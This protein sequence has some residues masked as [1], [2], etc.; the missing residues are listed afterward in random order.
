MTPIVGIVVILAI[1]VVFLVVVNALKPRTPKRQREP[2]DPIAHDA[3]VRGLSAR[4]PGPRPTPI[5]QGTR[6]SLA[7]VLFNETEAAPAPTF[8][9]SPTPVYESPS[10]P[11]S[12]SHVDHSPSHDH[13]SSSFDHGSSGGGGSGGDW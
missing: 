13:G 11:E 4:T 10:P 7:L 9:P 12:S 1:V 2:F 6:E 5:L 8:E 3:S